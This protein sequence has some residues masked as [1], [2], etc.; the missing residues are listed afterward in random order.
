MSILWYSIR[1]IIKLFSNRGANII[2]NS[3]IHFQN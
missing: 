3:K 1:L 2:L